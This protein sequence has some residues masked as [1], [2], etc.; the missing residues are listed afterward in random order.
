MMARKFPIT[1]FN[2][3]SIGLGWSNILLKDI[4]TA[5][6]YFTNHKPGRSDDSRAHP[7]RIII[8]AFL[9]FSFQKA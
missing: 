5:K 2:A 6:I 4:F 8:E 3:S 7:W 9:L 1:L